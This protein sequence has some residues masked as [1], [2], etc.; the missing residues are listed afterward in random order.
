MKEM[1]ESMSPNY[2]RQS[3]IEDLEANI[4]GLEEKLCEVSV[5]IMEAKV[6]IETAEE[7]HKALLTDRK[8]IHGNLSHLR[9][10]LDYIKN[11]L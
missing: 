5:N 3:Q 6:A 2:E 9:T 8:T 7:N 10:Q 1:F 11:E 4:R